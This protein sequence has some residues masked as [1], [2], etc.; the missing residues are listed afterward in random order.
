MIVFKDLIPDSE[1][2]GVLRR[3]L[4]RVDMTPSGCWIH[5]S[6][7]S[8]EGYAQHMVKYKN[9]RAHRLSWFLHRGEPTAGLV[10]DHICRNRR[11]VN[12]DHLREVT[13]RENTMFGIGP[14]AINSAKSVCKRG[15]PLTKDS[16]R[17][18]KD[19]S[20]ICRPCECARHKRYKIRRRAAREVALQGAAPSEGG[21]EE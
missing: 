20:R 2:E 5:R 1:K 8:Q 7:P 12:P 3:F 11:C 10:L 9:L 18:S 15:H 13:V 4:S 17:I 21:S 14:T 6:P 16:V 19:G